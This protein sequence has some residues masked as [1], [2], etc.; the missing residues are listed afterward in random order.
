MDKEFL[1]DYAQREWGEI[2][3]YFKGLSEGRITKSNRFPPNCRFPKI[4]EP[5]TYLSQINMPLWSVVAFSGSTIIP[6]YPIEERFF[7]SVY[8]L[9][10]N[11]INEIVSFTEETGKIQFVLM[12]DP[13]DY[14]GLE[15]LE[16][17]FQRLRPP[18]AEGIPPNQFIGEKKDKLL[19]EEYLT[20]ADLGFRDFFEKKFQYN[21]NK[22][23]VDSNLVTFSRN[24]VMAKAFASATFNQDMEDAL[25]SNYQRFYEIMMALSVFVFDPLFNPLQCT[26]CL[27][28]EHYRK[29]AAW[30]NREG[31]ETKDRPFPCELGRLLMQKLTHYPES[32]EACK[33]LSAIYTEADVQKL[34]KVI[35]ESVMLRQSPIVEQKGAE[36]SSILDNLWNDKSVT[37]KIDGIRFGVPLALGVVGTIS[38]GLSGGYTGLLSGLGFDVMDN[39]FQLKEESITEKIAKTF[40]SSQ[41]VA[42]FDFKK[43]YSIKE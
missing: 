1:E 6:L 25:V 32:L 24:Y 14:Q 38:A 29:L 20:L 23:L 21:W 42:I 13:R 41:Q 34:F 11:Q 33:Q 39:L 35:S 40:S 43:R 31:I 18:K 16:P 15:F 12:K 19:F 26:Q 9:K 10:T 37:R 17:I 5:I 27:D 22:S 7:E 2:E 4:T 8:G 36:L 30:A 28:I 3:R